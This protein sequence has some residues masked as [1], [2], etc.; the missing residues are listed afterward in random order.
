[1][2]DGAGCRSLI[3]LRG[4]VRQKVRRAA[5]QVSALTRPLLDVHV[6][7]RPRIN[8]ANVVQLGQLH[9]RV[10]KAGASYVSLTTQ[11]YFTN[12]RVRQDSH[13]AT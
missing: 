11:S 8:V 1:M 4:V 7:C 9:G 12:I 13:L 10:Y 2:I 5:V 6:K 3:L